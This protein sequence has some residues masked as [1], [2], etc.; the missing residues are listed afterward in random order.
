MTI[1]KK[2]HLSFKQCLTENIKNAN[3]IERK[4]CILS[5]L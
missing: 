3:K 1:V 4:K 5:T 2:E